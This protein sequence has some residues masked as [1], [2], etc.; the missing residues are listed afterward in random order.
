VRS[1]IRISLALIIVGNSGIYSEGRERV[2][3]SKPVDASAHDGV[4]N[5]KRTF[6]ATIEFEFEQVNG[7]DVVVAGKKIPGRTINRISAT[8]KLLDNEIFVGPRASGVSETNGHQ[9]VE[10]FWIE[11][12]IRSVKNDLIRLEVTANQSMTELL[13][14]GESRSWD[15]IFKGSTTAK[16]GNKVRLDFGDEKLLG[17]KCVLEAVIQE[18]DQEKKQSDQ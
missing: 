4:Q 15:L 7:S 14:A 3:Q 5:K 8:A 13:E 11:I 2:K 6:D 16:V 9:Y 10:D 17:T 1:W 18:K 12:K